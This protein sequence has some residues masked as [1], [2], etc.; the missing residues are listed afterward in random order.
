MTLKFL[1]HFPID[2]QMLLLLSNR[3][4]LYVLKI[5]ILLDKCFANIFSHSIGWSY[6]LVDY[7][8]CRREYKLL[9]LKEIF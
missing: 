9:E 1:A 5:N 8:L 3:S 4:F 2:L 6:H 7:L